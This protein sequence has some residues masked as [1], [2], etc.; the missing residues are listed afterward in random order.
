ML[1]TKLSAALEQEQKKRACERS[2][3]EFVRQG[4]AILEP[5]TPFVDGWALHAMCAHL[6]ALTRGDILPS[7]E[8]FHKLLMNVPP[9]L[10]KSLLVSVFWPAWEWGPKN[11]PHL[12]YVCVSHNQTLAIRD[13]VKCRVLIT[14]EWYRSSWGNRFS[15]VRDQNT[16]LK[17]ANNKMGFREAISAGGITGA[18]G[19][20]LLCLTYDTMILTSN[21]WIKI[22]EVVE[23]KLDVEIAGYDSKSI[24]WQKIELY[25]KNPARP[26]I[27]IR[28]KSSEL[29]CTC[30]H[31][32]FVVGK[33][34][35]EAER[36]EAGDSLCL[37]ELWQRDA[38][39]EQVLQSGMLLRLSQNGID[40][41]KHKAMR[42]LQDALLP[43]SRS[44]GANRK[45]RRMQHEMSG[46]SK[47][48]REQSSVARW[49]C[50]SYLCSLRKNC[51]QR[52]KRGKKKEC[53]ILLSVVR[54]YISVGQFWPSIKRKR[55]SGMW[56][57]ISA[58]ISTY[59]NVLERM[60]GQSA[61]KVSA[62]RKEWALDSWKIR[63]ALSTR[64]DS[65]IQRKYK[66]TR[67]K[68]LSSM[69]K[70]ARG[71]KAESSCS[72]YRL[73]EREF[74][75][76]ESNNSLQVVSRDNAWHSGTAQGV[77]EEV[78][79]SV[80]KSARVV[81]FTYNLKVSPD[82]NYFA[83]GL[84]VHNC[85]DPLSF[86]D[87]SS[88]AERTHIAEWWRGAAQTR[89][90]DMTTSV[91]VVIMQRL[92]ELD[93][94]G[95][96]LQEDKYFI[97]L[98]LPMM[99]E[100]DR[101]CKTPIK[102]TN[103]KNNKVEAFCDIRKKEG[104]LLFPE[105]FPQKQLN[106]LM[107]SLGSY[108]TASQLQQRPDPKGGGYIKRDWFRMWERSSTGEMRLPD[109]KYI[110]QSYDTAFTEKT[111][112]DPT[113]CIVVGVFNH[114][115]R[116]CVMLLDAWT[117]HLD[118]P[119]LRKKIKEEYQALYAGYKAVDLVLV[120]N[121]GSGISILQDIQKMGIT[122]IEYNPGK[123]DK[124]ARLMRVSPLIE[125]GV[126]YIPESK[127]RGDFIAWSH[128][129]VSEVI[130]FPTATH[131]EFVDCCLDSATKITMADGSLKRIDMIQVGDEVA[132][133]RGSQK[134]IKVHNNGIKEL[135]KVDAGSH[136]LLATANHHIYT[137]DGWK[138]VDSLCQ[139]LD[140]VFLLKKRNYQWLSQKILMWLPNQL[141]LMVKNIIAI[142]KVRI[143]SIRIIMHALVRG[144]IEKCG[145]SIMG[146]FLKECMFIIK[147][148]IRSTMTLITSNAYWQQITGRNTLK[149]EVKNQA[150]PS[151]SLISLELEE[152]QPNGID[153]K[154]EWHG[155]KSIQ[156]ILFKKRG[157]CLR[158]L[159]NLKSHVF[160][161][162]KKAWLNISR[163][164]SALLHVNA[165]NLDLEEVSCV[166]NT[167]TTGLTFDLTVENEHC[168]FANGILVHNCSQALSYLHDA[169]WLKLPDDYEA[170]EE[171]REPYKGNPYAQ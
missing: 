144:F 21:G 167:N 86:D 169:G 84:L 17:F 79:T 43:A 73:C 30:D 7:K 87:A 107:I 6:E 116:R 65:T 55:L 96:I 41:C 90:N 131:D 160:G 140:N 9:G 154:K 121:K 110:I 62:W 126:F 119:S 102:W 132:T 58:G 146:R 159:K 155:I 53:K 94:S 10:M 13:S 56:E 35:I 2:L 71:R 171:Y 129:F 91:I 165:R 150:L 12:R 113:G 37:H 81:D 137:I 83:N 148:G 120:E 93:V 108:G 143:I 145:N 63:K 130:R 100:L 66:G 29:E 70:K 124:T 36:I 8:L 98:C 78:V 28:T 123:A 77:V 149:K 115:G 61:V 158:S 22:G 49:K 153:L 59:S 99:M 76:D 45:A 3:H 139:A 50:S 52:T 80:E 128:A 24:S 89:I 68:C 152:R 4:W 161:V 125:N 18:R 60:C 136:S 1:L 141:F 105:R 112:G 106:Q 103:P 15:L 157:E 67:W 109:F 64:M 95:I 170:I 51:C 40:S 72:S 162:V 33:G 34:W 26:I 168:Y 135:W 104:E 117:E 47:Q 85:D 134:V 46:D 38:H 54:D 164:N 16:K 147:M 156:K 5:K 42:S 14:S 57:N 27:K 101:K 97:H 44:L 19:D 127:N 114:Q 133:P 31:P 166:F 92:H 32:I 88:D 74:R 122:A 151:R 69:L 75:S 111:A 118:Y 23:G 138:R 39:Q 11:M 142:Q 163:K 25:E 20:R 48:R 82:H